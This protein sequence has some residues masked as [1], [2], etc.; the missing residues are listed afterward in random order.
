MKWL[1]ESGARGASP[2]SRQLA[3]TG[4][5][6][7]VAGWFAYCLRRFPVNLTPRFGPS[8]VKLSV[9]TSATAPLILSVITAVIHAVSKNIIGSLA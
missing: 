2:L 9:V 6:I 7:V 4:K 5:V 3:H 8:R 1:P